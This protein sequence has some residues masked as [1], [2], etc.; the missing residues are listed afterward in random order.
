MKEFLI[1][2]DS[3]E[4]YHIDS[5]DIGY[6]QA[7]GNYSNIFLT[8]GEVVRVLMNLGEVNKAIK[9]CFLYYQKDFQ[10]VGRSL[11]INKRN[12]SKI[13]ITSNHPKL[14]FSGKRTEDYLKG[15]SDGYL[16]G[17]KDGLLG[18]SS[19]MP[20]DNMVLRD[21]QEHLPRDP[22]KV[23]LKDLKMSIEEDMIEKSN[24]NEQN[25]Q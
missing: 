24:E 25:E 5:A 18:M 23:F 7:L 19:L 2:G 15:Y 4:L 20:P 6:I 16:A 14:E 9:K 21:E 13:E 12:L 17:Q 8:N 1:V 3:R 11:I 22:M 10:R